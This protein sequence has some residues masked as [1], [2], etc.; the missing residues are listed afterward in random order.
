[1]VKA[2]V[3]AIQWILVAAVVVVALAA[4]ASAT[5]VSTA[6]AG[7]VAVTSAASLVESG[8]FAGARSG[9]VV[10]RAERSSV[11]RRPR[12][13]PGRDSRSVGGSLLSV[14]KQV[15]LTPR[16][17]R[18]DSMKPV[19]AKRKVGVLLLNLGGPETINVSS[20]FPFVV[21]IRYCLTCCSVLPG[22]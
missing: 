18:V 20:K 8:F 6:T 13:I 9:S 14:I 19:L 17:L 21:E 10:S 7:T 1:M 22:C 5:S 12:L 4:A 15:M 16:Q 11:G 3:V 2:A